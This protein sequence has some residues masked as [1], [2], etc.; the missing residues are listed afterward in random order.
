MILTVIL[1][2]FVVTNAV[3]VCLLFVACRRVARHLQ[4]RPEAVQS[5]TENVLVP[6][7]GKRRDE[8]EKKHS[9]SES[10]YWESADGALGL[11]RSGEEFSPQFLSTAAAF[12]RRGASSLGAGGWSVLRRRRK[13]QRPK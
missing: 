2:T 3:Y 13:S 12:R 10:A 6:M 11:R 9:W 1:V 8:A 5:L 4:G 7:F